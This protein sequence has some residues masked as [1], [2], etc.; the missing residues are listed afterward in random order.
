MAKLGG[1]AY[2][3]SMTGMMS[4][5]ISSPSFCVGFRRAIIERQRLE[6]LLVEF[7]AA[8]APT[9]DG[10][11]RITMRGV[12]GAGRT[13]RMR[14]ERLLPLLEAAAVG[15][16]AIDAIPPAVIDPPS[17]FKSTNG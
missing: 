6:A 2:V 7:L 11:V 8:A 12:D 5:S 4:M 10:T 3:F 9:P 15:A 13:L 14:R 1:Y 17:K 16:P